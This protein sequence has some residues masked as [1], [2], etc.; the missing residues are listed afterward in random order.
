MSKTLS[1]DL[2]ARLEAAVN[3]GA[4]LYATRRLARL[5]KVSTPIVQLSRVGATGEFKAK[6]GEK[7]H[8]DFYG[9][10]LERAGSHLNGRAVA[11]ECKATLEPRFQYSGI[12]PQQRV[13]LADTQLAFVLVDFVQFGGCR[14]IPWE[15][16][17]PKTSVTPLS[18]WPVA[19]VEFLAPVLDGR[20]VG[21]HCL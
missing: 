21:L 19:A 9:V 4:E 8:V 18:G 12:R 5:A 14:L 10:L 11:V 2:G 20:V 7:A 13:W 1:Q 15:Q 16:F 6:H 17:S 3:S